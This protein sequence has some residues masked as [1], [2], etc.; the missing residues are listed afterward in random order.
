MT[1]Q[2]FSRRRFPDVMIG[3][4]VTEPIYNG[5]ITRQEVVTTWQREDGSTYETRTDISTFGD[6]TEP[7]PPQAV[8]PDTPPERP[9]IFSR[10]LRWLWGD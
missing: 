8:E 9:G 7:C 4:V 3:Q 5:G 2:Q 1:Q 6:R 10:L